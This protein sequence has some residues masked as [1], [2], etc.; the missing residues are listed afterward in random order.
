MVKRSTNSP[1]WW[2]RGL[3]RGLLAPVH[4][5]VGLNPAY[6]MDVR[7]WYPYVHVVSPIERAPMYQSRYD[8][9]VTATINVKRSA[10]LRYFKT[11]TSAG[12]FV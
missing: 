9:A 7:H 2:P 5:T 12:Y 4:W 8:L 1:I 3:S 11:V 6:G 10:N